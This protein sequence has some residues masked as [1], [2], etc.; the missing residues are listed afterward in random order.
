MQREITEIQWERISSDLQ[1]VIDLKRCFVYTIILWSETCPTNSGEMSPK[2][3]V[4]IC[5][6]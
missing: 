6:Y 1:M 5:L 4:F 3:M 2:V